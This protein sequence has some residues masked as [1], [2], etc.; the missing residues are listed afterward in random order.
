MKERPIIFSR[1]MVK[2]ILGGQKTQTRRVIKPQPG[3]SEDGIFRYAGKSPF[4]SL[5]NTKFVDWALRDC[6]FG[7]PGDRLWVRETHFIEARNNGGF[8]YWTGEHDEWQENTGRVWYAVDGE[9]PEPCNHGWWEKRPSIYMFREHSR[10]LLEVTSV[11]TERVQDISHEDVC[12]EGGPFGNSATSDEDFSI[13]W[14]SIN[15]K[16]GFSWASN[17]WVW[18]IEFK[19]VEGRKT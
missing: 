9:P 2:A 5:D 1:P 13:F 11:R 14:D 17:P 16:R 12:R 19:V 7:I 18:V 3:P 4:A 10:I 15:A 6:S 8:D